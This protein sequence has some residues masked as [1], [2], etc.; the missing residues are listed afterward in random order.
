[1]AFVVGVL[2][3]PAVQ[4]EVRTFDVRRVKNVVISNSSGDVRITGDGGDQVS[5]SFEKLEFSKKCRLEATLK[6][7]ELSVVSEEESLFQKD[8]CRVDFKLSVA[9]ATPLRVK[10]GTGDLLVEGVKGEVDFKV[11]SGEVVIRGDLPKV[12]GLSGAGKIRIEGLTGTGDLKT[13]SGSIQVT[14]AKTPAAGEFNI[15]AGAGDI[16]IF[17]PREARFA[18]DYWSGVGQFTNEFETVPEGPFKL[19]VKTGSG[20]LKIRKLVR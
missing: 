1:M 13:G 11:G 7:G 10:V 12:Q 3:V 5:V 15:K 19:S 16:E 8:K 2:A 20:D 6:G 9:P 17:L 4:G 14:Y 18:T